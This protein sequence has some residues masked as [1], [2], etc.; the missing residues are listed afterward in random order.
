MLA[1]GRSEGGF[2]PYALDFGIR[3]GWAEEEITGVEVLCHKCRG[4]MSLAVDREIT[5]SRKYT[6]LS[7]PRCQFRCLAAGT[8]A[9]FQAGLIQEVYRM[10]RVCGWR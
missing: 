4:T 7:C 5:S 3:I 6:A 1:R 2:N 8:P 9:D 10:K